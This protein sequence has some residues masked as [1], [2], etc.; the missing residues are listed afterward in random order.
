[1]KGRE[2]EKGVFK[3][4]FKGILPTEEWQ[5]LMAIV[6]VQFEEYKFLRNCLCASL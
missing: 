5:K 4:S 2:G 1:M 6:M 3:I